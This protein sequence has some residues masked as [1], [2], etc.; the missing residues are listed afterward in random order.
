MEVNIHH[1]KT[2]LSQLI[3]KAE[4]GEDVV[5]ARA[6]KPVV[7]LVP[8]ESPEQRKRKP[9]ALKGILKIAPDAFSPEVDEE[10]ARWFNESPLLY[11]DAD[12]KAEKGAT[13]KSGGKRRARKK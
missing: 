5:I 9:G 12:V 2:N 7:R 1:A 13:G 8:I 6:G 4:S 3:L 10:I 11:T